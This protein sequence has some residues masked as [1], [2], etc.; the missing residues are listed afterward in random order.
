[1][2]YKDCGDYL[3][4]RALFLV[5]AGLVAL[6]WASLETVG[7]TNFWSGNG[8][9]LGGSGVWDTT[10][11][12][13]GTSTSGPFNLTWDNTLT[14]VTNVV[15]FRGAPGTVTIQSGGLQAN[16]IEVA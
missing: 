6:T 9:N 15:S 2:Y 10:N 16:R 4:K 5:T 1:M 8:T 14:F 3:M 7:Q 13:F 11:P 12:R